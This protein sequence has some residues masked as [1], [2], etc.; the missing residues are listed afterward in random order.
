M[1][2][3]S[4][5]VFQASTDSA[6]SPFPA[7]TLQRWSLNLTSG[8]VVVLFA[9]GIFGKKKGLILQPSICSLLYNREIIE[10]FL[11]VVIFLLL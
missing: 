1:A 6:P 5:F 7:S 4:G 2:V 9:W 10:W 8:F 11:S 3:Q